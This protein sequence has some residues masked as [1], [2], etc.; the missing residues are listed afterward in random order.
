MKK[1]LAL[2]N[3]NGVTMDSTLP[4]CES[5][6]IKDGIIEALGST[7]EILALIEGKNIRT[8]DLQGKAF[9]PGLH[10]CH[11]HMMGTGL[12]S[13]GIDLFECK[14][15]SEVLEKL[16]KEKPENQ[17][18][19]IYG[20]GLDES[21]LKE[22]RPPTL[23][24]LDRIFEE[25]PVYIVDR[26][27]HYTLLNTSGLRAMKFQG[28]EKG[29]VKGKE[30]EFTGR[31]HGEAN[32]KARKFFFDK[33]SIRQRQASI[34]YV[35]EKAVQVGITTIHAMEGGDLSS[36]GDIPV[37]LEMLET[38]PV[39]VVLHWCC[40]NPKVVVEKGLKI[41][42][43]DILLDGSIGSRTA[44]FKLPYADDPNTK[45]VLYFENDWI[46]N[47]IV[48]AH[49]R[50]LQT[51][52]HAIGERAIT[53]VLDCLEKALEIFPVED[54]RFK[55]EHF[56]FPGPLDILRAKKLGVVI[57]TQPSFTYL[58]GGYNSVYEE[59]VGSKRNQSAYPLKDLLEAGII[60]N[61][62][63]DSNVTPMDPILGIHA[64]ANPP[65]TDNAI[66]CEE[67][68][69]L[70]TI[71]GAYGVKEEK[72]RGSLTIGKVGDVTVLSENPLDVKKEKIKDI[73]I[74]MTI[75]QGKIVYKNKMGETNEVYFRN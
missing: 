68:I 64:A 47:Y 49:K 72:L 19:W 75:Y 38:L 7:S 17:E 29:L 39:H 55:I 36:D 13:I 26:G 1:T 32:G 8:F 60:V 48:E 66:S 15:V 37:F 50:G 40:T 56:G 3:G 51:G 5:I 44:A 62:G 6:F 45:G 61:G 58:R 28:D 10:D 54:H 18:E 4:K 9:L 14:S 57:S 65:F 74:E 46:I 22:K 30:G 67:A 27:L 34:R 2:I 21:R 73:Q 69:R 23:T 59:R 43:T 53:Q 41:M 35:A 71:N 70:F 42:G 31:V 11:V 25:R 16:N 12:A 24:D 20:Y 52:F 33:I 63:S